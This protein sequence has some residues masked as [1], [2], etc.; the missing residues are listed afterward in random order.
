MRK[1]ISLLLVLL[2]LL[3]IISSITFAQEI[4]NNGIDDDGDG[5]VDLHDPD[6]SCYFQVNGNLLLNGSFES[7]KNC[8]VNYSYTSEYNI[9]NNWQYGTYTNDN[10][11]E[12]Y[13]NFSCSYDSSLVMLYKPP[14]LPLPDGKAFVSIR[15]YVYTNLQVKETDIAKIY[16]GQ[17][18]QSP[19][20][21]SLQY[22]ASFSAGR[23]QSNDDTAFKFKEEPFTVA[24][25][26]HP[27]CNAA[28]F[29]QPFANS[30]GCPSNYP[31]WI[32]LGKTTVL[33]KGKWIQSKINFTVPFNINLIEIGPDCSIINPAKDLADSTTLLDFYVYDLDDIHLLPTKDFPF[34]YINDHI[35]NSCTQDSLL[36][37]P[38]SPGNSYQWY[39]DSVAIMGASQNIYHLPVENRNGNYNV[40]INNGST[41]AISEPFTVGSN[42]VTSVNFPADTS[43]CEK[44]TLLFAPALSGI[45]Y[46][47][48]GQLTNFI[49]VSK[50]GNYQITANDS[51]GCS[52]TFTVIVRADN[53]SLG[54]LFIPNSF[55]P[56]GDGRND[57]F[58][59]PPQSK[60]K[61]KSFL[62]FDRWGHKV[63]NSSTNASAWDGKFNGQ[64]CAEGTYVYIITGIINNK[65]ERIKGTVHLIR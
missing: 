30:N 60:I 24:I 28:P 32:L 18:L 45:T 25:F 33:S 17:C 56:N 14:A 2:S 53:C 19:L 34:Q 5:L 3:L 44:D 47:V 55:T 13:H 31:G 39:R 49:K 63:Y 61:V 62:I 12:Y 7:F 54:N 20:V 65:Q 42:T 6:C 11:A 57:V 59:I 22:T 9:I 1:K 43:F 10:E 4:C 29:G 35:A 23:F 36:T 48:N 41:C 21:P 46:T 40:R 38:Y 27:D 51:R 58:R 16:V 37:V 50:E 15:Q 52:K 26:G 64:I 8:P